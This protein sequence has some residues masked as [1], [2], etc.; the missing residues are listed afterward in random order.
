MIVDEFGE[1]LVSTSD[2]GEGFGKVESHVD[3]CSRLEGGV[4]A[5]TRWSE[6]GLGSRCGK[7][8]RGDRREDE[9]FH[10]SES[11][12]LR[13]LTDRRLGHLAAEDKGV[14]THRSFRPSTSAPISSISRSFGESPLVPR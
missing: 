6:C 1:Y 11:S 8:R 9:V 2:C 12:M 14:P 4:G 13:I 7:I 3:R 5:A 10:V